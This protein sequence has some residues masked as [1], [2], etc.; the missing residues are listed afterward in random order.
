[1][2]IPAD[3]PACSHN[4]Y[5]KNFTALTHDSGRLFMFAADQKIEH[6]ND[7]FYGVGIDAI[8][9]KPEHMFKIAQHSSI[10][11]MAVHAGLLARYGALYKTVDYLVK[12]NGKTNITSSEESDPM[13]AQL[14]DIQDVLSF[15]HEQKLNVRAI[16]YTVYLGS[17]YESQMLT[18]AAQLVFQAHQEGLIAVLW[19]YPRAKH[20]IDSTDPRLIAGSAGLANALG[21]DFVKVHAPRAHNNMS[22]MQALKIATEAAG[23]TGVIVS[24]GERIPASEVLK[25]IY[26]QINESGASGCAIG[27]NIFQRSF[28][29][30]VKLTNAISALVYNE[31]TYEQAN[32][33]LD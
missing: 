13:S 17:A 3:V 7:D 23:N 31:S 12:L 20:I 1:M 11:A 16:G 24:G 28:S 25:N 32:K 21:A 18:Q 26:K 9:N 15:A 33:L 30:A 5:I 6:L 14:W 8:A 10:G 2:F 4:A 29:D 22:S 27:R 19:V